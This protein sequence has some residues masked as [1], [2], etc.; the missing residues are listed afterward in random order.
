M[1]SLKRFGFLHEND[2]Q[3]VF[4]DRGTFWLH[5]LE[6]L[7]SIEFVGRLWGISMQESWPGKIV[8]QV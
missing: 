2:G 4:T 7:F 3:V 1:K 6:D 8:L 5:A